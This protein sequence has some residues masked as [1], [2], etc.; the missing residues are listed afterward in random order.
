MTSWVRLAGIERF[1]RL[2][3]ALALVLVAFPVADVWAQV[4]TTW[5]RTIGTLCL[6]GVPLASRRVLAVDNE[7]GTKIETFSVRYVH[8]G[9]SR[10]PT[11]RVFRNPPTAPFALAKCSELT[12]ELLFQGEISDLSIETGRETAPGS[13][14]A[15][16]R[17]D[18]NKL[19]MELTR[20]TSGAVPLYGGSLLFGAE[21]AIA[22]SGRAWIKNKS[23]LVATSD[24]PP[25]GA[26]DITSWGR[27]LV[28]AKVTLPGASA[29]SAVDM[30]AGNTN[31]SVRVPLKGG[32]AELLDG[33]FSTSDAQLSA[34]TLRLPGSIFGSAKGFAGLLKLVAS[35]NGVQ[36]QLLDVA[37]GADTTQ[38]DAP[39]SRIT[40]RAF[41]GKIKSILAVVP[42]SGDSLLP[43]DVR[44]SDISGKAQGCVYLTGG[45]VLVAT[46]TCALGVQNASANAGS[47][48]LSADNV[49][50][51][52]PASFLTKAGGVVLT[53]AYAA[54]QETFSGRLSSTNLKLGAFEL[55]GNS[56]QLERLTPASGKIRIPFSFSTPA[57]EGS[58]SVRL[59]DGK[60]TLEGALEELRGKGEILVDV[61][62]LGAWEVQVPAGDLAFKGRVS[63]AYEPL[64][65]GGK[66]SFGSAALS[67]WSKSSLRITAAG[68]TGSIGAVADVLTLAD[69]VL[70]L[71]KGSP[72]TIRGPAKFAAAVEISH[73][74][75][76]G[77][78]TLDKGSLLLEQVKAYTRPGESAD[79]GDIRVWDAEV[80]MGR[81]DARIGDGS[82]EFSAEGLSIAAPRMQSLPN[83]DAAQLA[84][85]GT[86]PKPITVKKVSG[87]I[88]RDAK[89]ALTVTKVKVEDLSISVRDVALGQGRTL[90]FRGGSLDATVQNWSDDLLVGKL[91]LRNA[92]AS[93]SQATK[94]GA[95]AGTIAISELALDIT[96]GTPAAP[97]GTGALTTLA[98]NLSTDSKVEIK[99]SCDGQ[100]DF[101]GVPVRVSVQTGPIFLQVRL[102]KGNLVGSGGALMT[103]ASLRSTSQYECRARVIDWTIQKEQ[104]A[105]YDYPC[106]TWSEPFRT[107][108]GWT[109][110][111]PEISIAFDRL[112][113]V[114]SLSAD[115]FF[116]FLDLSVD[117]GDI[118]GCGR[119]GAVLPLADVSYFITPRSSI[120]IVNSIFQEI[121]DATSRPFASAIVS[122]FGGL[123]GSILP[124]TKNGL[125]S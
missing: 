22:A 46:D 102:D 64:V 122:G 87:P 74:L 55:A 68:A 81:L 38:L 92:N 35:S 115:G 44:I 73:D 20:V 98:L 117:G 95:L 5:A 57:S 120:G 42:R 60:V 78:A 67:F 12:G 97:I 17:I 58:W 116:T 119:A 91:V 121:T 7:N 84:W 16:L 15:V 24:Q 85:V 89:G 56:V 4:G 1:N 106:P 21:G 94:E 88:D 59:P 29:P 110:I 125:C 41:D 114:R 69:P 93:G 43:T 86:M 109:T 105:I 37:L 77:N 32:D 75:A 3:W 101:Q 79:V 8:S 99:E 39:I 123:V 80:T 26:V 76:N 33:T 48:S 31:I 52:L 27:R 111:L 2:R 34:D 70:A 113:R 90:R 51:M 118:K 71:G 66:P 83:A 6:E 19:D 53:A 28:G 13:A 30:S 103:A 100:T 72:F 82:N 25:E 124:Q 45:V 23:R 40:A 63:A 47:F 14:P 65:L 49:K 108:R 11:V 50:Q 61:P 96:G 62:N 10:R 54:D 9:G 112:I 18:A 36:L 107:C 104:R